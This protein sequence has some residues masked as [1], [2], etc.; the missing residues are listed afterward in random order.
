MLTGML[1]VRNKR[2]PD[3]QSIKEWHLVSYVPEVC[4]KIAAR[5][6]GR[7]NAIIKDVCAC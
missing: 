2:M 7:Q 6:D 4:R 3:S 5:L 1:S